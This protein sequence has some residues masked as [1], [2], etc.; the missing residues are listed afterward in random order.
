MI[1][2]SN[3]FFSLIELI[4]GRPEHVSVQHQ[5]INWLMFFGGCIIIM[6]G[7]VN[8]LLG[9]PQPWLLWL[10]GIVCLINYGQS[11][12]LYKTNRYLKLI[13][14]VAH[15]A[16]TTEAWFISAGINGGVPLFI[17][18]SLMNT[19][20]IFK[21]WLRLVVL[22]SI[23]FHFYLLIL[24]Q[25]AYPALVQVYPSTNIK[26]FGLLFSCYIV[27]LYGIGC[28]GT[29]IHNLE[30]RQRQNDALL[31]AILPPL[32]AEKLKT[33]TEQIIAHYYENAS[34][35]FADVV[36]F[37]S[38]SA[39]LPP[40][41]LVKLLNELFCDFDDLAQKEGVEK[42]KT[43]G[44]CYM[45]AAG[46]LY[47]NPAHAQRLA[48]LAVEMQHLVAQRRYQ[49][50]QIQLHIGI[51]S[52]PVIAGVIG[53]RKMLYDLWG[54]TVNLANYV[55]E[56]S[57]AGVIQI[58]RAT[59]ELVSHAFICETQGVLPAKEQ[60]AIEIWQ[61]RGPQPVALSSVQ[62]PATGQ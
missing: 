40:V 50:H 55:E 36:N 42:I 12:I 6:I 25:N 27:V 29:L 44:D 17:T 34:V 54:E 59:Y 8:F 31:A 47:P 3:R 48:Q 2:Y 15:I 33:D 41:I 16:A 28:T 61:V 56:E 21:G 14:F 18:L 32:I 57:P 7:A 51:H 60:G 4:C 10:T 58:T 26:Q 52:G 20:I 30:F 49:G 19:M 39:T 22:L 38:L 13:F 37:T 24:L 23:Y 62:R 45:A 53:Q 35:L 46:V 11:R 5:I 1:V 9:I 43:I